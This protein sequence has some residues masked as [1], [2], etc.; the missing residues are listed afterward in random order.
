MWV[1]DCFVRQ[2]CFGLVLLVGSVFAP[3]AVVTGPVHEYQIDRINPETPRDRLFVA[4]APTVETCATPPT[5]SRDVCQLAK[6]IHQQGPVVITSESSDQVHAGTTRWHSQELL[7]FHRDGQNSVFLQ[8]TEKR[9]SNGSLALTVK[10]V[11]NEEA[12]ERTAIRWNH[13][14]IAYRGDQL[15]DILAEGE[16]TIHTRKWLT[17]WRWWIRSH[18]P[19]HYQ[20]AYYVPVG[21]AGVDNPQLLTGTDWVSHLEEKWGDETIRTVALLT[22]IMCLLGGYRTA[23]KNRETA[24][25]LSNCGLVI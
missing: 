3:V 17:E 11:S 7:Y 21:N 24:P 5:S 6:Q 2:I 18:Q 14:S 20:G 23:R 25:V 12:F 9:L 22:G 13:S 16:G 8:P 1:F 10:P 15:R 4:D 19:I